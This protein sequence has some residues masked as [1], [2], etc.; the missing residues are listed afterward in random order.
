VEEMVRNRYYGR[1][2]E[3]RPFGS[4][5]SYMKPL[6]VFVVMPFS[7]EFRDIYELGIKAACIEAGAACERVDEQLFLENILDRI[8]SQIENADVIVGEIS[9]RNPNVFY[10]V[11]YAHGIGKQVILVTSKETDIPFD[12]RHYPHV[13]YQ[14]QIRT[15]KAELNKKILWCIGHPDQLKFQRISRIAA[16]AE[17]DSLDK[18]ITNYLSA[19]NY[20]KMSFE[21]IEKLMGIPEAQV[22]KLIGQKPTLFRFSYIK[23]KNG[24]SKPG[25]GL[26]RR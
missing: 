13:V 4:L 26:I 9:G 14:D 25:I 7:D 11:G 3:G 20:T 16:D 23:D 10:E 2:F 8:Y 12:L 5:D 19:N 18:Q 24:M 21:R 17:I 22:R 6:S 15:L 1:R